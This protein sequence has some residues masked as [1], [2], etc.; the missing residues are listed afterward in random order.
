MIRAHK[1][2]SDEAAVLLASMPHV[3]F[4]V[5]ERTRIKARATREP[6]EV[7]QMTRARIKITER[8]TKFLEWQRRRRSIAKVPWTHHLIP[9]I[10]R[11]EGRTVPRVLM[12]YHMTQAVTGHGCFHYDFHCM[13]WAAALNVIT[14]L[15]CRTPHRAHT[16]MVPELELSQG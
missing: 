3:I 12:S 10:I 14:A 5:F 1:T 11:W 13:G 8:K 15:A 9:N 6:L 7:P 4:L 2:V 16:V